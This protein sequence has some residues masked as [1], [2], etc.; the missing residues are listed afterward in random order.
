ML[1]LFE[2]WN[3]N[4]QF[5]VENML[6]VCALNTFLNIKTKSQWGIFLIFYVEQWHVENILRKQFFSDAN[7]V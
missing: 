4:K 3:L 2:R 6:F 5:Q 7:D 1:V